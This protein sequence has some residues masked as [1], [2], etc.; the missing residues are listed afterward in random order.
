ME[1][2]SAAA[3]LEPEEWRHRAEVSAALNPAQQVSY[4]VC[5][6]C[7]TMCGVRV[8]PCVHL[9]MRLVVPR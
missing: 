2:A 3:Q 9:L 7:T 8:R 4:T 1:A 5:L 6:G